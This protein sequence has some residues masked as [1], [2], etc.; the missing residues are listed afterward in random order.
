MKG[1]YDTTGSINIEQTSL[2]QAASEN[3][4]GDFSGASVGNVLT[5][6]GQEPAAS[7][8]SA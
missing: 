2:D 4:P 1:D 3:T 8:D 7:E 5:G 6:D